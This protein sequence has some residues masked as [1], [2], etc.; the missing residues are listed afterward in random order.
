MALNVFGEEMHARPI[1]MPRYNLPAHDDSSERREIA[2]KLAEQRTIRA[3][4]DAWR[5]IAKA[6]SFEAWKAV[7][8]ALAIGKAYA[9]RIADDGQTWRGR[10][11]IYAFSRWMKAHGFG[12]MPKSVR[13]VAIELHENIAAITAWRATLPE[14]QRRRLVHPLSNVRRWRAATTYGGKSSADYK[15]EGLAAWRKFL[16]CVAALPA[17]DQAAMWSIVS[18]A[19]VT[20]VAA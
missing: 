9:Q 18:Q 3:G 11:Y 13:S 1:S 6:H 4:R 16:S 14:R 10:N 5:D 7:G 12:D 2:A 8:A 17:A 19:R 20:N 15:A